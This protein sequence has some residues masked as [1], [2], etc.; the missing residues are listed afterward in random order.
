MRAI[1]ALPPP[2]AAS[3]ALT[4]VE[5][6]GKI[7]QHSQDAVMNRELQGR[8]LLAP[9]ADPTARPQDAMQVAATNLGPAPR[10]VVPVGEPQDARL[11]GVEVV[12]E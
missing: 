8:P 9:T 1:G 5:A 7:V 6:D 4:I 2:A 10:K 3:A 12:L 11:V